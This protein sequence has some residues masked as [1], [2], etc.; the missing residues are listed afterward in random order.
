[1][2]C[3][4][5]LLCLATVARPAND[6]A[7]AHGPGIVKRGVPALRS[8]T[9]SEQPSANVEPSIL[10]VTTSA[11][12]ACPG[13]TVVLTANAAGMTGGYG[14]SWGISPTSI[15]SATFTSPT[16]QSS[17]TAVMGNIPGAVDFSV[18]V[19]DQTGI[20]VGG[21]TVTVPGRLHVNPKAT[22]ANNGLSWPDA[23][24]SLQS[25][26][27]YVSPC[28]GPASEIWVASGLYKPTTTATD[29]AASFRIPSGTKVYGGFVINTTIDNGPIGGVLYPTS[30]SDRPA[31]NPVTD[32]PSSTTFSGDINNDNQINGNS[33]S[34]VT[35]ENASAAT[36][37]DGVVITG[38]RGQ[39]GGIYLNG[40]TPQLTNLLISG[41]QAAQSGNHGGG[42]YAAQSTTVTLNNS[43]IIGNT[44]IN[45]GGIYANGPVY[46]TGTDIS[47]NTSSAQGGGVYF[48]ATS[49][50]QAVSST[51]G[52]NATSGAP[53]GGIY[54][55][56]GS[57]MFRLENSLIQANQPGGIY[58]NAS[59]NTIVATNTQFRQ[60]QG[61]WGAIYTDGPVS[62]SNCIIAQNKAISNSAGVHI[63]NKGSFSAVSTQFTQNSSGAIGGA[64]TVPGDVYITDCTISQNT[65]PFG[66]AGIYSTGSSLTVASVSN[67]TI[68]HN[69]INS[70]GS[71]G[72]LYFSASNA[73]FTFDNLLVTNNQAIS[74]GG[75]IYVGGSSSN[76]I[77]VS[78][79][80]FTQNRAGSPGGGFSLNGSVRITNC[81]FS[82]NTA[83]EGA[84][85]YH[86]GSE[87]SASNSRF[88]QNTAAS[89]G[90]GGLRVMG[91]VTI[92]GSDISQNTA[93]NTGGGINMSSANIISIQSTTISQN[94]SGF[95]GGGI[96]TSG[97][98]SF[99]LA[100]VIIEGNKSQ[101]SGGGIYSSVAN[102]TITNSRVRQN[103]VS[104]GPGGGINSFGTT[105]I[106]NCDVSQNTAVGSPGGGVYGNNPVITSST[107]SQ[108]QTSS[109]GGGIYSNNSLTL[110]RSVVSQ[111]QAN[112]GGGLY[113]AAGLVQSSTITGNNSLNTG[114]GH[115]TNGGAFLAINSLYSRNRASTSGGAIYA[116]SPNTLT[117]L[118]T[119]VS[120]NSAI[121][122][123][124]V[125]GTGVSAGNS[126]F[127][128]NGTP[129]TTFEG[130]ISLKNSLAESGASFT[131]AGGNKNTDPQF[132]SPATDDLRVPAC[133]PAVNTGNSALF[134]AAAP[135]TTDVAGNQRII[136]TAIDMGAYEF[137]T[138][139]GAPVGITAGPA[140][141]SVVC[142]GTNFSIPVSV[143]GGE[144]T[145]TYR[146]YKDGSATPV[147]SQTTATLSFSGIQTADA[148]T[149]TLVVTGACNSVT[150]TVFSLSVN[151]SAGLTQQPVA[152]SVVCTGATVTVM[153]SATGSPATGKNNLSYQ[154]Y[155]NGAVL[156]GHASA[157]AAT[158]SLPDVTTASTGTYS[159]VVTGSCGSLTSTGFSLHV[160]QPDV[161]IIAS[162]SV[163]TC[164]VPSLTLTA[165]T[166]E[167][168]LRWS[169][170]ETT[171]SI[172][173]STTGTNQAGP[174]SVTV[175]AAAGCTAAS[176]PIQ[177]TQDLSM[178]VVSISS[179]TVCAGQAVTLQATGCTGG[180]VRWPNGT[181]GNTIT[182]T[183]G[184]E[185]SYITATCTIGQC[186]TTV[187][188]SVVV[189]ANV[190][191]PPATINSVSADESACPVKLKG[192]A[193]G[194]SFIFTGP[195]GYVFSSVYRQPGT[196]SVTAPN[197]LKPGNYTFYV[198]YTTVCGTTNAV[199]TVTVVKQCP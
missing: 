168:A 1:M 190:L 30:I 100:D 186:S 117:L 118:N 123:A 128:G 78:N 74:E 48:N 54:S 119:S 31:V 13:Q 80:Q 187:T 115:Y 87:F 90:G 109:Q 34:V 107:I 106:T 60:H 4:L 174:Y 41:N 111:N 65:A 185:T 17:V 9:I 47:Q 75:G 71:G 148:G 166:S 189:A 49:A 77:T 131:D 35:F 15:G 29:Q 10:S 160:N 97:G 134:T 178:P 19:N 79:S 46:L 86:S 167:T 39:G 132:T 89:S 51:I 175:T 171:Q 8:R 56:T 121:T 69:Q 24:T 188:G 164:T 116:T 108:N 113:A 104:N 21:V 33:N 3:S 133:S 16:D 5:L 14:F 37:L 53:A 146:W 120:S 67:T 149:Y 52:Q 138:A 66:G 144:P 145:T 140:E 62:F 136:G 179:K 32:E 105:Y 40:G 102:F 27:T 112:D 125:S 38:G 130:S 197:A 173:V 20:A 63:N 162:S 182:L 184:A 83:S 150:S 169:T 57:A 170:G 137:T 142:A 6:K 91:N 81:S 183:A 68:T 59:S 36:Q 143:T 147:A 73:R 154:W 58:A 155:H 165:R 194:T 163:L 99:L 158:L 82:Q 96:N 85:I 2:L 18:T 191:P 50:F 95:P 122:G 23:F 92:T 45:G 70:S 26:L 42:I 55:A 25:A 159:V 181:E 199:Q 151:Q 72:G 44:G 180:T 161:T 93:G 126:I 192:A 153:V 127:W 94:S 156:T 7:P 43:R 176:A 88:R 61:T 198:H 135:L 195:N 141:S 124:A 101:Y 98:S 139:V 110:V 152:S 196:Y 103:Q 193:T 12:V 157:T 177:L 129:A 11:S 76:T 28:G 172:V 84:G 114:G 22:G 64:A